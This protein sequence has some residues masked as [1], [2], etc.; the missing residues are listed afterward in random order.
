MK[1]T[2]GKLTILILLIF[3]V[4]E[5]SG[6]SVMSLFEA[7]DAPAIEM[8][9]SDSE[10]GT[11]E[12]ESTK[13]ASLKEVWVSLADLNALAPVCKSLFRQPSISRDH[14]L[15]SFSPAIP[16]PPPNLL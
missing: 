16:T 9:M 1:L 15:I 2:P 5:K 8:I 10:N 14:P 4:L 13:E 11:K 6:A 3:A 7:S 12:A